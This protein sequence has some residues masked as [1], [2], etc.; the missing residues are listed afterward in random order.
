SSRPMDWKG[1]RPLATPDPMGM[2]TRLA[3]LGAGS[4]GTALAALTARHGFPT[5][6]WGRDA[7]TVEAINARQENPRYLPGIVLPGS[8]RATTDLR[9]ALANSTMVLVVVPSHA[10]ADTLRSLAPL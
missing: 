6:L 4:W 10:F 1:R 2:P 9:E 7:A 5:M 3:V 8:L